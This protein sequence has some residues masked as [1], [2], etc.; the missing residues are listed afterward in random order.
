MTQKTRKAP[1][2]GRSQIDNELVGQLQNVLADTYS[3]MLLLQNFH[4]NVEGPHFKQLHEFFEEQYQ[5]FWSQVDV[6][7]ERIRQLGEMVEGSFK[8]FME[9]SSIE[10]SRTSGDG[11]QMLEELITAYVMLRE[12]A[13]KGLKIAGSSADEGT[14]D[15]IIDQLRIIEKYIWMC[16]SSLSRAERRKSHDDEND[17]KSTTAQEDQTRDFLNLSHH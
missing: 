11:D 17:R 9:N 1:L 4:W 2:S 6:I 16:R 8:S 7:A 12:Q 3:M 10:I 14:S 15:I 5:V 13:L